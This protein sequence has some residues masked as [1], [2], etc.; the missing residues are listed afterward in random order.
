[1]AKLLC[2]L[3]M[4]LNHVIVAN[5]YVAKLSFNAFPESKILAKISKFTVHLNL[6]PF[7]MVNELYQALCI[8]P[9]GIIH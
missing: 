4:K 1:M 5:F 6:S 2:H 8:N 7:D 9:D 3:L